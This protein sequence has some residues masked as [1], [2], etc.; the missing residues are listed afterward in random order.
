MSLDYEKKSYQ[1]YKDKTRPIGDPEYWTKSQKQV[2]PTSLMII[3]V[4]CFFLKA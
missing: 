2:W 1:H 3:Q 4:F